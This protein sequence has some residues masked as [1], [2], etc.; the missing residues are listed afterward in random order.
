MLNLTMTGEASALIITALGGALG[1]LVLRSSARLLGAWLTR[2]TPIAIY[3]CANTEK[4]AL[5]NLRH[6][7]G[8]E[9]PDSATKGGK[10]WEYDSKPI[11]RPGERVT[12]EHTIFGPYVNDFGKPGFYRVRYRIC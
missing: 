12:G 7:W 8:H 4:L 2:R 6:S 5:G 10:A 3:Q 9:V 11:Q 1:A